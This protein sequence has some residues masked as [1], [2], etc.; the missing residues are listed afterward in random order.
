MKIATFNILTLTWSY[1][2]ASNLSCN[3]KNLRIIPWGLARKT[4]KAL[5]NRMRPVIGFNAVEF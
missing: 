5:R 2:T 3:A 1:N 4:L